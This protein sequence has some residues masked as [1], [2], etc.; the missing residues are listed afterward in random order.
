MKY[1]LKPRRYSDRTSS[2]ASRDRAGSG[3]RITTPTRTAST[4]SRSSSRSCTVEQMARLETTTDAS[5]IACARGV[6]ADVDAEV[7]QVAGC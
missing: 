2:R 3:A 7:A 1:E 6:R 5:G 4:P